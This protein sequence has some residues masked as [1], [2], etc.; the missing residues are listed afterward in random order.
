MPDEATAVDGIVR[1]LRDAWSDPVGLARR[2]R[3]ARRRVLSHHTWSA[4]LDAAEAL[5]TRV[6][7]P[8]ATR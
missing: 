7:S 2:G 3:C 1:A 5:Y 4:K 8:L 6:L